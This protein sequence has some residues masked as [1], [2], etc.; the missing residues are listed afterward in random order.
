[1]GP[2]GLT[3]F[4]PTPC[5]PKEV[6]RRAVEPHTVPRQLQNVDFYQNEK[7]SGDL[8]DLK[9]LTH[10]G[11]T[12]WGQSGWVPKGLWHL[13]NAGKWGRAAPKAFL[14]ITSKWVLI[15]CAFSET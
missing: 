15:S 7:I 11:W 2:M 14:C 6:N 10:L 8:S 1:M 9:G 5:L 4:C 12:P 13:V 3:I